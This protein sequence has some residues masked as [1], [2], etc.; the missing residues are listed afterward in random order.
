MTIVLTRS[1]DDRAASR[2]SLRPPG[3]PTTASSLLGALVAV[4]VLF[5]LVMVVSSSSLVALEETQST[6]AYATRQATWAVLGLGGLA[7]GLWT[8]PRL[9]RRWARPLLVG[10][11]AL[12][13][14]VYVVGIR[15][16]GA[17]RWLGAGPIQLQP[18]ELAKIAVIL[19]L[20]D[21]LSKH[22]RSLHDWRFGLGLPLVVL[23]A[24]AAL[25]VFQ[26]NL[27]T[28]LV[29][30]AIGLAM[31]HAAGSRTGPL[32]AAGA[33]AAVFAGLFV[34]FSEFRRARL[35]AMLDPW[36]NEDGT[37]YQTLQAGV[38]LADGGLFGTGLGQSKAKWGYLPYAHTDF[39]FAIIGEELGLIGAA[40]TVGLFVALAFVGYRIAER[41]ADRFSSLVAVGI[42]TWLVGQAFLNIAVVLN[43][44]PNTG[45]PLPFISY[46]GTSLLVTMTAAGMLLNIARHPRE[47]GAVR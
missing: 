46:G 30:V 35:M 32:A 2:V 38:G 14:A 23:G 40:A 36:A 19:V 8:S 21:L 20:A 34:W 15:V 41:A 6:W 10:V 43:L 5:G 22:C 27:G 26:P 11:V 13:L 33:V 1:S 7:L 29:I 28:T 4:L 42:T 16:N 47:D 12:L 44:V 9:W 31:L 18:S 3:R 25:V 39:V 24:V 37:A 17:R 45:V